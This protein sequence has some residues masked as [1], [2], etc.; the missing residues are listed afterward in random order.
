M[1]P[2]IYHRMFDYNRDLLPNRHLAVL[3]SGVNSIEDA[4][5]R[6]GLTIGYPGWGIIYYTL[7]SHLDRNRIEVIIETGT[8][9]G[10]TTIVLAQ[11]L[12][13]AGCEG[14]VISVELDEKNAEIAAQNFQKAGVS[15]RVDLR[16]G[17][18]Q[19][20][21]PSIVKEIDSTRFVFLDASHLYADVLREFE[22]VL[23]ILDSGALVLFDNTYEISEDDE[24]KYVHGA[25]K[26]IKK[27]YGGNLINLEKVSWF[28]PGL[29][30][31]QLKSSFD[32]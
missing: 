19:D 13:D 18:S 11:A 20:I 2:P 7:L 31:L 29:A 14:K 4:K 3:E 21:L 17:N 28:T 24:D 23:P 25:I 32:C 22:T 16:V 1:R 26:T 30:I 5:Q 10:C 8:N 15:E 6:T 9:Q 27:K 12:I